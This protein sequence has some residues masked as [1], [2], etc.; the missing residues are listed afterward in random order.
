MEYSGKELLLQFFPAFLMVI[1]VLVLKFERQKTSV[2]SDLVL[3]ILRFGWQLTRRLTFVN[4]AQII[5]QNFGTT[6]IDYKRLDF[7]LL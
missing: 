7:F 2:M 6:Y 3:T 1:I 4:I 5:A